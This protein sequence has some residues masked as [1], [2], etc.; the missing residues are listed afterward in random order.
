MEIQ[1][2]LLELRLQKNQTRRVEQQ[3]DDALRDAANMR[4]VLEALPKL[5][6]QMLEYYP[7]IAG[8]NAELHKTFTKLRQAMRQAIIAGKYRVTT[9][10]QNVLAEIA[11]LPEPVAMPNGSVKP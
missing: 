7:A 9:R 2:A 11:A 3:R 4:V 1:E 6:R 5:E 10:L 8:E